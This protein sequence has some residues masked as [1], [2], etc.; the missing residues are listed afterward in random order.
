MRARTFE[1][2]PLEDGDRDWVERFIVERWGSARQVSRGKVFFPAELPG[3]AAIQNG[4][5][6]GL[7]TYNIQGG[8]CEVGTLDSKVEGIGVGAAL[9]DE[10]KGVAISAGCRRLWLI[11]T[12]DNLKALRFYQRY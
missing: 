7:I 12:N 9:L 8:E 4:A 11:T 6:V 3:F 1:I 2:R 5:P 10:V